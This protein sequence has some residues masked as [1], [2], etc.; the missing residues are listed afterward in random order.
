MPSASSRWSPGSRTAAAADGAL[1]AAASWQWPALA[2]TTRAS[3]LPQLQLALASECAAAHQAAVSNLPLWCDWEQTA[4]AL[5][6]RAA[7][8]LL[9]MSLGWDPT[10]NT[11]TRTKMRNKNQYSGYFL[12]LVSQFNAFI[13][14]SCFKTFHHVK[15][16]IG[17]KK[18]SDFIILK[19][20]TKRCNGAYDKKASA[21]A[22]RLCISTSRKT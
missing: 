8:C 3:R 11:T 16:C 7:T 15:K 5:V 10:H 18:I 19:G 9:D 4:A 20:F 22:N 1:L 6:C 21:T 14:L 2:S 17:T 13:Y 12:N